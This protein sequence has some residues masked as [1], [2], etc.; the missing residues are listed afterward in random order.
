[1]GFPFGIDWFANERVAGWALSPRTVTG[2]YAL[3]RATGF[4]IPHPLAGEGG[5]RSKPGG[6]VAYSEPHR[7]PEVRAKRASKDERPKSSE[8][9]PSPLRGPRCARPPQG[10][11]FAASRN[12]MTC[13]RLTEGKP[14][15]NS[16]M[17]S[18]ALR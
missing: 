11:G 10:D 13:S 7:H 17:E 18:P 15:K 2:L 9:W 1:M 8:H 5:E 6:A 4:L 14:T 3:I 16:S 12:A